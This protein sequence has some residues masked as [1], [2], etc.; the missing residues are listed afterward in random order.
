MSHIH[1]QMIIEQLKVFISEVHTNT[2]L[3]I[4]Y[5]AT[6]V[7]MHLELGSC[8][9]VFS[10]SYPHYEILATHSWLKVLWYCVDK[11]KI[12]LKKES[13]LI[14]KQRVNDV[15]LMDALVSTNYFS[16]KELRAI[17]NCR[18]YLE[19]FFLSDISS[20]DG[21]KIMHQYLMGLRIAS[22]TSSRKW[23][24][25]NR[26][27][28]TSWNLWKLA[29][30]EVW[31][32]YNGD[33]YDL[34]LGNW[35]NNS[36]QSFECYYD[37]NAD[38]VFRKLHDDNFAIYRRSH[39][40]T[41]NIAIF[42][43][44]SERSTPRSH[45]VPVMTDVGDSSSL[46][47]EAGIIHIKKLKRKNWTSLVE[48]MQN[49]YPHYA[50]LLQFT[51]IQNDGNDL[52]AALTKHRLIS[53]TD[54]SVSTLTNTSAVSW[55]INSNARTSVA[56]GLSGCPKYTTPQDSYGA[57]LYG[58]FNILITMKVVSDYHKVKNGTLI[59]ACDND[60][61]LKIGT[62]AF[63]KVKV[64]QKYFDLIWTIQDILNEVPFKVIAKRVKGHA[65]DTKQILNKYEQLNIQMD[66]NA[67]VFR[68]QL[69]N[70]EIIHTP[71]HLETT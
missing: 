65:D 64:D 53:V 19:V 37:R 15:A 8:S 45:W 40:R 63:T 35:I 5:R 11:Y 58:I 29:V 51:T 61:S 54:A 30:T 22:M 38:Q 68:K 1:S 12:S 42:P 34:R 50:N 21:S 52:V 17:N 41:R 71:T 16:K 70:N 23:P 31:K 33:A 20:G 13:R 60:A 39:Q 43:L 46:S 18:L 32:K 48:F 49:K 62:D 9:D 55:I 25:Q 4:M 24:R 26:P 57:A 14:S 27:N 36:H 66:K 67:K 6:M 10:L 7:T 69:E 28:E 59:L 3:G 56:N 47:V 2:Q 44:T